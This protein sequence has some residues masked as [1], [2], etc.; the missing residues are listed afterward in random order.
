MESSAAFA[1]VMMRFPEYRKSIEKLYFQSE[2]FKS[3]C[4]D[5]QECLS[6][7]ERWSRSVEERVKPYRKELLE[8]KN[9]L[10][11]EITW[12]VL[13]QDGSSH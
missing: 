13:H 4:E 1:R 6:A 8:L 3:L 5:Y 9:D 7:I 10:E 11:E 2:S 12:Y